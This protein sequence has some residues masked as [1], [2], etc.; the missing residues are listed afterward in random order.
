MRGEISAATP[1][2]NRILKILLPT[3]LAIA[4]SACP[5]KAALTLTANSGALVPNATTVK[6]ITSEGMPKFAAK[7]A[8]PLTNKSAPTTNST[9]PTANKNQVNIFYSVREE[10]PAQA[11]RELEMK[12][13]SFQAS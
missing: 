10:T 5:E 11:Y 12:T 13:I 1:R 4:N 6:P 9:K 7:R 8:A 2:M 3:A